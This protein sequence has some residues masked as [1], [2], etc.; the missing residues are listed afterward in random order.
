MEGEGAV[1][2]APV[3]QAGEHPF[4]AEG[5]KKKSPSIFLNIFSYNVKSLE[6]I[7]KK[8]TGQHQGAPK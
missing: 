7:V 1:I 2:P 6:L 4:P 3:P 8:T 5:E